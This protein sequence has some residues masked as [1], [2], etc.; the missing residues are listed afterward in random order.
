MGNE[1]GFKT[2]PASAMMFTATPADVTQGSFMPDVDC[3]LRICH[4]FTV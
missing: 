4:A 2:M 3:K 1:L